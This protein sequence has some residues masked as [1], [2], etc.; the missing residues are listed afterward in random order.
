MW[1]GTYR[2]PAGLKR[3]LHFV[4]GVI[5]RQ[6]PDSQWLERRT[7]NA[8]LSISGNATA[9][10]VR[11]LSVSLSVRACPQRPP[12]FGQMGQRILYL[13]PSLPHMLLEYQGHVRGYGE[14][15]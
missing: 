4:H 3:R 1:R 14:N 9:G 5:E 15:A 6:T 2:S 12:D 7:I 11:P 10:R 13:F 8:F